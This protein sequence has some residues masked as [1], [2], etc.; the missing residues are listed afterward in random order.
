MVVCQIQNGSC[1]GIQL[2]FK[3][4]LDRFLASRLDYSLYFMW[5][6]MIFS[7]SSSFRNYVDCSSHLCR[8]F[9]L[10]EEYRMGVDFVTIYLRLI[11]SLRVGSVVVIY[12]LL[13]VKQNG[14][15]E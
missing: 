11:I 9:Y 3:K 15:H 7:S 4:V 12:M 6:P 14:D 1:F 8:D 13:C 2:G 5:D 10:L